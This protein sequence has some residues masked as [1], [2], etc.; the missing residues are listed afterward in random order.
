MTG[1]PYHDETGRFCSKGEMGAAVER[2][3]SAASSAKSKGERENLMQQWFE[4]KNEYEQLSSLHPTTKEAL[5]SAWE[6][7]QASNEGLS[8][9]KQ[10]EAVHNFRLTIGGVQ[11]PIAEIS[12]A[13]AKVEKELIEQKWAEAEP[14][15]FLA[16][17]DYEGL[18]KL[19]E[20]A[21][22]GSAPNDY[23]NAFVAG[24]DPHF[25]Q[26]GTYDPSHM[27]PSIEVQLAH[28]EDQ[29]A[30]DQLA[31]TMQSWA[32]FTL[33]HADDESNKQYQD[34]DSFS[35]NDEE[36]AVD[37]PPGHGF[38]LFTYDLSAKGIPMVNVYGDGQ[39]SSYM[40]VHG[41]PRSIDSYGNPAWD[42]PDGND[43]YMARKPLN[44]LLGD[45][46]KVWYY[47]E[48][49]NPDQKKKNYLDDE[50]FDFDDD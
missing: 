3:F 50:D 7:V 34:E 37:S 31:A 36:D 15:D 12:Q 27:L 47:P 28:G 23:Q 9:E 21:S 24:L 29:A 6:D 8:I 25:R 44:E 13:A 45:L 5:T 32:N 17:D 18:Q 26:S 30:L 11:T 1:N 33:R 41:S 20:D 48:S 4:I 43:L 14:R 22:W 2:V 16:L 40:L 10:L 39:A 46:T 35:Y 49:S 38:Q 19:T 42:R